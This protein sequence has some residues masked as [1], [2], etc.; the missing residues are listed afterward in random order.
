MNIAV[1]LSGGS[2][3]RFDSDL[4]KQYLD[5]CGRPVVDYVLE[6]ALNSKE[7][8]EI[9]L[10]IDEK[11]LSILNEHSNPRI[12]IVPNGKERLFSVKNALNYIKQNYDNCNNI[13]ILQ[14]VSPFVTPELIDTYIQ[15]LQKYDV[16]TTAQK[17]VGEIFNIRKYEKMNRNNY[18]FCHSPEAFKFNELYQHIDVNSEYSE[19]IYHYPN[20]PNVYYYLDF[21]NNIKLTYK[22]D[23]EYARLLMKTNKDKL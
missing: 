15:L 8:D 5:L 14:A 19:L 21:E 11:Y 1:I 9:V 17:C 20:T 2:G 23:L 7:I 22:A 4:P 12:K 6:A 18:Y 16:V 13:I 3:K 10:V